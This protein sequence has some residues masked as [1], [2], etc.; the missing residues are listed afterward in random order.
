MRRSGE[1]IYFHWSTGT[2]LVFAFLASHYSKYSFEPCLRNSLWS[3]L[4]LSEKQYIELWKSSSYRINVTSPNLIIINFITLSWK[5]KNKN[6]I[7]S[8][9]EDMYF[10]LPRHADA[11][12]WPCSVLNSTHHTLAFIGSI[13]PWLSRK[14]HETKT[15][16]LYINCTELNPKN[17]PIQKTNYMYMKW[18]WWI[19]LITKY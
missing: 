7:F 17:N 16:V 18:N 14:I 8:R 10:F 1:Y 5:G 9:E 4:L 11:G 6:I 15:T 12:F 19:C 13:Y 3:L 2:R